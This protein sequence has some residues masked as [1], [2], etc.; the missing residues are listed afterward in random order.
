M[1]LYGDILTIADV[2]LLQ[3]AGLLILLS[4]FQFL[5]STGSFTSV[6]IPIWPKS[7]GSGSGHTNTYSRRSWRLSSSF[8]CGPWVS[9][10]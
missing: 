1:F 5:R 10:L 8:Q 6:S 2:D 4:A 3:L 7:I 9:C